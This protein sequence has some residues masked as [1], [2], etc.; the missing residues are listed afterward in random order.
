M[1]PDD[2]CSRHRISR[3]DR[4]HSTVEDDRSNTRQ[5]PQDAH[6][7][8]E[9]V[10]ARVL[11]GSDRYAMVLKRMTFGS[12]AFEEFARGLYIVG[13]EPEGQKTV[14]GLFVDENEA[15]KAC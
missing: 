2:Q 12:N 3:S 11:I 1:P 7:T 6:E 15:G 13:D 8:I 14:V 4:S 5:R 10:I 9:V